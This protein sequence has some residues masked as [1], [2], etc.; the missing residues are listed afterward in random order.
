MVKYMSEFHKI[1][2]T[3]GGVS[4]ECNVAT[5]D[6]PQTFSEEQ[7]FKS[8]IRTDTI[9]G[10]NIQEIFSSSGGCRIAYMSDWFSATTKKTYSFEVEGVDFEN[11]YT[12]LDLNCKVVTPFLNLSEG[13]LIDFKYHNWNGSTGGYDE[14]FS[15]FR[16]DNLIR[17]CTPDGIDFTYSNG[18][19]SMIP[20]EYVQ[21]QIVVKQYG[22]PSNG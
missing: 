22:V 7:T 20:F 2:A 19:K 15:L 13:E 9:N 14:G 16:K 12:E 5:V 1:I 4:Y 10:V 8:G 3:K 21:F 6:T 18:S 17:L 11:F